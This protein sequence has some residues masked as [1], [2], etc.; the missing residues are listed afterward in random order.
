MHKGTVTFSLRDSDHPLIRV[1]KMSK[2]PFPSLV[3]PLCIQLRF[4]LSHSNEQVTRGHDIIEEGWAGASN[5]H[6]HP[7]PLTPHTNIHKKY[8]KH[9]FFHFLSGSPRTDGLTDGPT[10]GWTEK[11]SYRVACLRLK[12]DMAR[13]TY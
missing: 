9:S 12:I 10:D 7:N 1:V 5:P 13:E 8:L 6:P 11:A 4:C 2:C 3:L